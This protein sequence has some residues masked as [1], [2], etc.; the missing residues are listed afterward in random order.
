[1]EGGSQGCCT[2]VISVFIA[3]FVSCVSDCPLSKHVLDDDVL[4]A[5]LD[6]QVGD[7][8]RRLRQH[9]AAI[10]EYFSTPFFVNKRIRRTFSQR[11]LATSD[12]LR[13][14]VFTVINYSSLSALACHSLNLFL[15][16]GKF[17]SLRL[18]DVLRHL[19]AAEA[20]LDGPTSLCQPIRVVPLARIFHC[21]T[22]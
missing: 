10:I 2:L 18:A 3:S 1:M 4:V 15:V 12:C 17:L 11:K 14:A 13:I 9:A 7:V 6:V 19:I 8:V 5:L 21:F 22:A 20:A 16:R